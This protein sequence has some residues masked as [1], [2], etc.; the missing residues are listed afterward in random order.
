MVVPY[1]PGEF[2]LR[3]LPPLRT[4]LRGVRGLGLLVVDGYVDLDPSGRPGLGAQ[5]HAE[6]G[7]PVVG[8][9]K[10]AF[11]TAPHAVAV[12]RGGSARPLFVTAAGMP[13]NNA[14]SPCG[15]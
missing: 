12:L 2:Y 7:V 4:V 1:Q 14:G 3:E 9:A 6:S 10:T 15:S 8:V 13:V 5:A 11:R